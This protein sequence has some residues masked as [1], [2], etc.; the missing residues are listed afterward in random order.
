M[1]LKSHQ[2]LSSPQDQATESL[3]SQATL[4]SS[5]LLP[6]ET[7]CKA[8]LLLSSAQFSAASHPTRAGTLL[9]LTQQL[10]CAINKTSK[11][12]CVLLWY[13]SAPTARIHFSVELLT[14]HSLGKS[15]SS[16]LQHL[17]WGSFSLQSCN[18]FTGEAFLLRTI[19]HYP[20]ESLCPRMPR[21]R[22]S[23]C[24]VFG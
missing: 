4:K 10:S 3:Q 1:I 22:R 14:P 20:Y 17:H 13:S 21:P 8:C 9:C 5:T 7:L 19:T 2:S 6:Q 11:L 18:T 15:S 16:E 24:G 12:C 23:C